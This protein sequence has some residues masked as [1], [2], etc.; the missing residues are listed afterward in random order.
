MSEEILSLQDVSKYYTSGQN[1]VVGLDNVNLTF[2]RGEFVAI[3]GESGSGKSTLAHILGGILPYESGE[4][5]LNGKPTSHYDSR[6]W[7][8]YRRDYVSFISQSYGILPGCTVLS[9][10]ISALR[11]TGMDAKQARVQAED[12]LR[13]VELWDLR[14][15]RAAKLSSG[16]KQ[17]L[18][19]AR[20]LAKPAPILLADEPTGNLDAE[21][22]AKIID[23]LAE[24]SKD[25]LVI[26]ITHELSEAENHIT[27]HIVI[28]D[29]HVA[30]NAVLRE[31]APAPVVQA[32]HPNTR[33]KGLG[34]YVAA[35]QL[36]SRPVWSALMLLFFALT[37]FAVFAFG[38]TFLANLDDTFTHYYDDSAFPNGNICRV[39]V[40]RQ[41]GR[42]LTAADR[43]QLLSLNHVQALE[44]YS[45]A[46]DAR[47]AYR[48]DVDYTRKYSLTSGGGLGSD[49]VQ[50]SSVFLQQ[51]AMPF[52]RTIPQLSDGQEFL[53]GGRLP[54]HAHE[55]VSADPALLGQTIPVYIKDTK[56][57]SRNAYLYLEATV[58]GTTSYGNGLYFHEDVG[59]ILLC[60]Q[61]VGSM[62]VP[63][64][65]L[66]GNE[67]RIEKG[68]YDRRAQETERDRFSYVVT[69]LNLIGRK[70]NAE[71]LLCVGYHF[72][73]SRNIIE[74]SQEVFDRL[75]LNQQS[76][77][78]SLT[79]EHYA[80]TDR[81]LEEIR[82]LGYLAISPYQE[83]ATTINA[84]K[85]QERTQTLRI[86]CIAFLAV[87]ALQIVVLRSMFSLE[88]ESFRLLS[89]IGL[90]CRNACRSIY[91]QTL[92]LAALG[93]V[94]GIFAIFLCG[95][96]GVQR[97]SELL[98][99]LTLPLGAGLV[100]LHLGSSL[101]TAGWTAHS[102]KKQVY[103]LAVEASD[104][105]WTRYEEEVGV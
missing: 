8:H 105:D 11:L 99:Y 81:V 62:Y 41:D 47:Y 94:I 12:I 64:P 49:Y 31:A 82:S 55:V 4:L 80:Y 89:N 16:Q 67:I 90:D 79:L 87:L 53:T 65:D 61:L 23:L 52:L 63:S 57:W 2:F 71:E 24:A 42:E 36:R 26:L 51:N 37:A 32:G 7:E 93:L 98:H 27:R 5:L 43:E 38:G 28:H 40:V 97:I 29:G 44:P 102:L 72:S 45:Y 104:L 75:T 68:L 66:Y 101:L 13:Q 46:A 15:R 17:R 35:L 73:K 22:S 10:V 58:V 39:V 34:A 20:A 60:N 91:L 19:I 54:A 1:V 6:E 100:L 18:S 9:N 30:E 50:V 76:D 14:S 59:N 86:C 74:V 85:A 77:Q 48:L 33:K 56:N 96:H 3:T 25:R 92:L 70:G 78:A 84:E 69:N 95:R 103:P 83:G 88:T 21:N